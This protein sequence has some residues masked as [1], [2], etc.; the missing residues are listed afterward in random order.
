[1]TDPMDP[2][3]AETEQR[4]R[5]DRGRPAARSGPPRPPQLDSPLLPRIF[6]I[7]SRSQAWL[8]R[9]TGGRVGGKWRVGSGF[10][11]PVPVL[12]LEHRGRRSGRLFTTPLLYVRD[13]RDVMVVASQGG[14][15]SDPQWYR[16]LVAQPDAHVQIGASRQAVR[17][18]VAEG[19]ERI[20]RWAM[21]VEAYADFDTY[22]AWTDREIPV[23]VLEPGGN[24]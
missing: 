21:L 7:L 20:R 15:P 14:L 11:R 18:R 23:V 17:A 3:D 22:Q 1:M 2:A 16:N 12:L 13:G 6:R 9:R 5:G 24:G 8:Y 4:V 19:D 10:R